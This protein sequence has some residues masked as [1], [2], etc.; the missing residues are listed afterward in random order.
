[1]PLSMQVTS[2][3]NGS[4]PAPSTSIRSRTRPV[5]SS[6][7]HTEPAV[8]RKLIAI[9]AAVPGTPS[10]LA[11]PSY[12]TRP[13]GVCTVMSHCMSVLRVSTRSVVVSPCGCT[14][15]TSSANGTTAASMLPQLGVVS[16]SARS[17]ITWAKRKSRSTPGFV[18]RRTMPTLLV[19]GLAP[20]SPSI[21]RLSG[22]PSAA[23]RMRSRLTTSDGRSDSRK[24][25]PRDVPPRM[26]R[27]GI[28][29]CICAY[30]SP[31]SGATHTISAV[32][33][34]TQTTLMIAPGR[35]MSVIR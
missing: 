16:T 23:S 9:G 15:P 28:A 19:S 29:V 30:S 11:L 6:P 7:E 4:K 32:M 13:P 17:T 3:E 34:I 26:N 31:S 1:M 33:R 22:D 14:R 20:P 10:I 21:C 25:G 24:N 2:I 27:Q 12:S 5:G 8:S 35:S 18:L